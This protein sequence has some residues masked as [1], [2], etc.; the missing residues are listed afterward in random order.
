MVLAIRAFKSSKVFSSSGNFG[1]SPV[2]RPI[3][4]LAKSQASCTCLIK[5]NMSG[6]SRICS[7]TAGSI[8]FAAQYAEALSRIFESASSVRR[9]DGTAT[10]DIGRD[11]GIFLEGMRGIMGG[12]LRGSG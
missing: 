1:G 10:L 6:A 7:I 8:F 9:K 5:G 3:V 4:F 2:R 12:G 11:M